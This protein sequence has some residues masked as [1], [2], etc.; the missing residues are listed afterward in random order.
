M[1]ERHARQGR[2]LRPFP[3]TQQIGLGLYAWEASGDAVLWWYGPP[4]TRGLSG[5][6]DLPPR[7][8]SFQ[9][10]HG[11]KGKHRQEMCSIHTECLPGSNEMSFYRACGPVA[12][13]LEVS[14]WICVWVRRAPSSGGSP[15]VKCEATP[16]LMSQFCLGFWIHPLDK[17]KMYNLHMKE[18]CFMTST[19]IWYDL[20][21]Y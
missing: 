4:V 5:Y 6:L 12:L 10:K 17:L 2:P 1:K 18:N 15:F 19:Y 20:F 3:G 21:R 14:L 8:L 9:P 13:M 11:R 7:C 16:S